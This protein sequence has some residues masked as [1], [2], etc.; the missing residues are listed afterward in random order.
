MSVALLA[1][2]AVCLW[3]AWTA[4]RG[5][6]GAYFTEDVSAPSRAG[7]GHTD[8]I[9]TT[10]VLWIAGAAVSA[11]AAVVVARRARRQ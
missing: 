4:S 9:T 3:M 7:Q 8:G 10:V 6:Q 1:V 2:A 5:I 11:V